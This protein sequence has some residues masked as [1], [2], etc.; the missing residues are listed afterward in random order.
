MIQIKWRARTNLLL[1]ATLALSVGFVTNASSQ[2][3]VPFALYVDP[4]PFAVV[5]PDQPHSTMSR[6]ISYSRIQH[7]PLRKN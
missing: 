6:H 7:L 5:V 4:V 1:V 3:V 2:P